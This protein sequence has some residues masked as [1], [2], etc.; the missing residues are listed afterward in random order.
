MSKWRLQKQTVSFILHIF[1]PCQKAYI[2]HNALQC[3]LL[4]RNVRKSVH[5]MFIAVNVSAVP[6]FLLTSH[7]QIFIVS[8]LVVFGPIRCCYQ[9]S[10]SFHLQPWGFTHFS[11]TYS[12]RPVNRLWCEEPVA[13][14]FNAALQLFA[15]VWSSQTMGPL[16]L[17]LRS[18]LA[19]ALADRSRDAAGTTLTLC[20]VCG[21]PKPPRLTETVKY[22][23]K[24][25]EWCLL[26]VWWNGRRGKVCGQTGDRQVFVPSS[27]L[28]FLHL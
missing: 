26:C 19:P 17:P 2:A 22:C 13:F 20:M 25:W 5:L 12:F 3:T 15:S 16:C 24:L 27:T 28:S 11:F 18:L 1:L 21:P 7:P 23:Y 4:P 8:R 10:C 14:P 6:Y 9:T